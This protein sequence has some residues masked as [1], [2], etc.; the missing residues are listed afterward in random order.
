MDYRSY[1]I[2]DDNDDLAWAGPDE[3]APMRGLVPR[4]LKAQPVGYLGELC[5][6][7]HS[8]DIPLLPRS[9]WSAMIKEQEDRK[10]GLQHIW[11]N[12][13]SN[14]Q[15]I[16]SLDQNGQGYCWAYAVA[17]CL[18]IL[19]AVANLPYKRMSG[20]SIGCRVKNYR[21]EGGWG[22]LALAHAVEHGCNDIQ[23][24]PEK[25]MSRRNDTPESREN[26]LLYKPTE[27]WVDLQSPVYD[28]DL[29]FDQVVTL[30]LRDRVPVATDHF[31][32]GHAVHAIGVVEVERNS[33]GILIRNSWTD[34]WG[35]RG[36]AVLRGS[37][38]IPDNAVA[39]RVIRAA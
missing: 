5:P 37:K 38:A 30:I 20:H 35:D 16:P 19:R 25:S 23:G 24:W 12:A 28:R 27:S 36:T 29:S 26:A 18:E 6:P 10:S 11:A 15:H 33:F 17:G 2:D 34:R 22:A 21:D 4:D 32:W 39:P 31:F 7:M 3:T 8:V 1:I 14:G 13:L 9:D